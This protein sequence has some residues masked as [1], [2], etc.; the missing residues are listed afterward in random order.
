[1]WRPAHGSERGGQSSLFTT[2]GVVGYRAVMQL[3]LLPLQTLPGW[4]SVPDL[5]VV[6]LL[7]LTLFIP[8]AITAVITAL[9]MG[10]SWRAKGE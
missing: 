10:P 6:H 2:L 8:L 4:P 9:V 3:V 1:M 5:S 7:S